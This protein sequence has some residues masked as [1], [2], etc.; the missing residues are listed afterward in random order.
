M[1]LLVARVLVKRRLH[2][3][4]R[5]ALAAGL[6]LETRPFPGTFGRKVA[7]ADRDAETR[8]HRSAEHLATRRAVVEDGI[9]VAGEGA[10]GGR[11]ADELAL[12][13][14]LLLLHERV[15]SHEVALLELHRP[16]E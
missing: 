14:L 8:A 11:E 13:P 10:L 9:T 15:P 12:H 7:G 4:R 3:R 6:D 2:D 5:G 1:V 16:G